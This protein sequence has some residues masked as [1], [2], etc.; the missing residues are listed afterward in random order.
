MGGV[1]KL[2]LFDFVLGVELDDEAFDLV[3]DFLVLLVHHDVQ[4]ELKADFVL[5][6]IINFVDH[7]QAVDLC[8]GWQIRGAGNPGPG[9]ISP[10]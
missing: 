5:V 3:L 2:E 9:R 6:I 7:P 4:P 1:L 8:K 10:R